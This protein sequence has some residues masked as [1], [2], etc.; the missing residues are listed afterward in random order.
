LLDQT[1]ALGAV[2]IAASTCCNLVYI[3]AAGKLYEFLQ[4]HSV[5]E[6]IQRWVFASV[7]TGFAVSLAWESLER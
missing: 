4:Q 1:F 3:P 5:A 7:I 2:H 6:R